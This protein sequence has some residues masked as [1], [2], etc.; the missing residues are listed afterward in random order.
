MRKGTREH[1]DMYGVQ[2]T[3]PKKTANERNAKCSM[4]NSAQFVA[5]YILGDIVIVC[6]RR[7]L[8]SVYSGPTLKILHFILHIIWLVKIVR[9]SH[10]L[11]TMVDN[12]SEDRHTLVNCVSPWR[13][14]TLFMCIEKY[15]NPK[16]PGTTCVILQTP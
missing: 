2:R 10:A 12:L 7:R 9:Y 14:V 5:V 4:L 8:S 16:N 6:R 15:D 13:Y 3:P 11:H 1:A